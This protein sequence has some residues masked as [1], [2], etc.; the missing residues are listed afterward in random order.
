M[1]SKDR[2]LQGTWVLVGLT[3]L[4]A[5]YLWGRESASI[6]YLSQI[7]LHAISGLFLSIVW[8]RAAFHEFS[9]GSDSLKWIRGLIYLGAVITGIL[10][11][12]L[13]VIGPYRWLL[14][15]H[16]PTAIVAGVWSVLSLLRSGTKKQSTYLV[17]MCAVALILFATSLIGYFQAYEPIENEVLGPVTLSDNAMGGEAGP[18]FPSAVSTTSGN[19][20]DES[21]FLESQ[22]CG[23][24]GCHVDAV[25]QWESSAH[26][27]SS[28]NNQWY[29]KSIEYM[30]E[31]GGLERPKWCAGCHDPALLFA[32]NMAAPVDS[33]LASPAS[34]AGIA[35]VTCH[36]I[37]RV[38][39]T[40]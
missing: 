34:Q 26:H 11:L 30:Q 15:L 6:V 35:C 7:F 24:S 29:R 2:G 8:T 31:V 27:F 40:G 5:A 39:N 38:K 1:N 18:F 17:S 4:S 20:I 13:G 9:S 16:I 37:K 23:R 36:T 28:F 25:A 32:G 14:F 3:I 33:F 10:I 22:A 12:F 21:Y 19:L